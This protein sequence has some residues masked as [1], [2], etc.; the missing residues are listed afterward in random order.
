MSVTKYKNTLYTETHFLPFSVHRV[1]EEKH[2]CHKWF[3]RR[4]PAWPGILDSAECEESCYFGVM[5]NFREK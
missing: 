2:R 5:K 1:C 4:F 3:R